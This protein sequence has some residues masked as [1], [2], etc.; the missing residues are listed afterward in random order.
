MTVLQLTSQ[1]DGDGALRLE[2]GVPNAKVRATVIVESTQTT[3]TDEERRLDWEKFVR[4][5]AGSITDPK[6]RR[7][8]QGEF[9]TR[10]LPC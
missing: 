4:Q 9:P 3:M 5:T 6:F 2:I 1:T 10:A 8:A 7:H